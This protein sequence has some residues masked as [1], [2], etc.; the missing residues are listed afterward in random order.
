[1]KKSVSV[2]IPVKDRKHLISRCLDSVAAQTV[3][4]ERVIVVD[5]ASTDGTPAVVAEWG[6]NHPEIRMDVLSETKPGASAARNRGFERVDTEYVLF[7]D[8]DDEMLPG[9]IEK[10][11]A[12]VADGDVVHWKGD[13]IGLDGHKHAKAFH[14][15]SYLRKHFYNSIFSTQLFMARTSFI[16]KI[17]GWDESAKVWND[18]EIGVRLVLNRPKIVSLPETLVI[19]YSQPKSITGSAFSQKVGEW[20]NTLNIVEKDVRDSDRSINDKKIMLDMVDY[21]RV[22]LAAHY[23]RE[24]R[25]DA[26]RGLLRTTLKNCRLGIADR[27]LLKLIYR[28]TAL[29]GRGAYYLWK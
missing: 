15:R 8:S 16:K 25:G 14:T 29:G 10:A 27:M 4:P 6:R 7:F 26:A 20:E 24:G 18:W 1:M 19:I 9:L 2:V 17:G 22:I 3:R 23:K 5:N 12:A 21:R 11:L 13:V 28:Y